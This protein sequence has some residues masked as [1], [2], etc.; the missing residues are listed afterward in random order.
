MLSR[1]SIL[2]YGEWGSCA[3][4]RD[5]HVPIL[6]AADLVQHFVQCTSAGTGRLGSGAV[7][8]K[9]FCRRGFSNTSRCG[10]ALRQSRCN[11]LAVSAPSPCHVAGAIELGHAIAFQVVYVVAEHGHATLALG[12]VAQ[13]VGWKIDSRLSITAF[14]RRSAQFFWRKPAF[15][16][17]WRRTACS[18]TIPACRLGCR[19]PIASGRPRHLQGSNH[20]ARCWYLAAATAA[21]ELSSGECDGRAGNCRGIG[22]AAAGIRGAPGSCGPCRVCRHLRS[23]AATPGGGCRLGRC[24]R[25]FTALCD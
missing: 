12:R 6:Q 22:R 18:A 9:K 25:K 4:L 10:K 5:C 8:A 24:F 15:Q 16:D 21:A 13:Q 23:I 1:R 20:E 14:V 7:L 2:L 3:G 11:V 17:Y 19:R